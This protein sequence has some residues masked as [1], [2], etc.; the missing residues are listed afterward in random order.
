MTTERL[1][2]FLVLARTHSYTKAAQSLYISQ[3]ILSR[4]I[5]EMEAE[6]G[7]ALFQRSSHGVALTAA[8]RLL[9]TNIEPIIAQSSKT[10]GL[11]HAET[12]AVK[13]GLRIACSMEISYASH[14]KTF[15]SRFAERYRDVRVE[16]TVTPGRMSA[17]LLSDYDIV[18]S[19]CVWLDLPLSIRHGLLYSHSCYAFVP[20]GH[21]LMAHAM[22]PLS[23]LAGESIIVPYA[24]EMF[25]PYSQN[26]RLTERATHGKAICLAVENISSAVFHLSVGRGV[27]IAPRYV[28][29]LLPSDMQAASFSVAVADAGCRFKEYVY[30]AAYD[31]NGAARL[32]Y[33]ELL[34]TFKS[35][36]G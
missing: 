21:P 1:Y 31:E 6:M 27:L 7:A 17:A 22:L 5:Q 12:S 14:V 24:D 36:N 3:S 20:P 35:A 16:F 4:H 13:G 15:V 25:G 8:G 33:D 19:P 30:C 18:L 11:L 32:F 28:R 26:W 34:D 29:N 23:R 10:A 9:A 2:E